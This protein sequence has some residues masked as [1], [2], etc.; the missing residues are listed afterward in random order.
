MG[1]LVYFDSE[2]KLLNEGAVK[3]SS[4]FTKVIEI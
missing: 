4:N 1:M 3:T 2:L